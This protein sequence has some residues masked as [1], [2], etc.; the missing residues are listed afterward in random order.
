MLTSTLRRR[1]VVSFVACLV[2]STLLCGFGMS[3]SHAQAV[4]NTSTVSGV[5]TDPS[6]TAVPGATVIL[7]TRS[8]Q[9]FATKSDGAGHYSINNVALGPATLRISSSGL[10][11][12][13]RDITV[14]TGEA[15]VQNVVLQAGEQP[16]LLTA[17]EAVN[18]N[19]NSSGNY[20]TVSSNA[21]AGPMGYVATPSMG[22]AVQSQTAQQQALV[23]N[24]Q[25]NFPSIIFYMSAAPLVNLPS[26]PNATKISAA[27]ETDRNPQWLDASFT[28]SFLDKSGKLLTTACTDGSVQ[29]L[30]L[31]PQQTVTAI[32]NQSAADVASGINDVAG[33]L[34]SFYPGAQSQVTAATKAMNVVFQDI[35][36]P[37]PVAYEY[38]YMTGNC[39]FG[40]YFRPNTSAS[41]GASGEASILGIQTGIALLKTDKNIARIQVNGRSLSAWNKPPTSSS[42]KLFVVNDTPIGTIVLPDLSTIDYN[43]LT[44]LSMFPAL[45]SKADAMRILHFTQDADFLTFAKS[46]RLVGTDAAFDYVTNSSSGAFLGTTGP[47]GAGQAKQPGG[48][49]PTGSTEKGSQSSSSGQ[50]K[51]PTKPGSKST[52]SKNAAAK[53]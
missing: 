4:A 48:G 11:V 24:Q 6:G 49:G 1:L 18:P 45:I 15:V 28:L 38:S 26:T 37:Q 25:Y 19:D 32:K 41:A 14:A 31:L 17:V 8:G 5:V 13:Q 29:V 39:D 21:V 3:P 42:K 33:A 20:V 30:G 22:S 53:N 40:W 16:N 12:S 51:T 7:T 35:F 46:N 47:A 2:S 50:A 36:P 10:A 44:T 34:A 52:T 23:A 9:H 43:N 27:Q